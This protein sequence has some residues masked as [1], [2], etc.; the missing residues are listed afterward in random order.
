MSNSDAWL[1][2]RIGPGSSAETLPHARAL[3]YRRY[4]T[5]IRAKAESVNDPV[6]WNRLWDVAYEFELL[7]DSIERRGR[8]R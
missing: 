3:R 6:V 8:G 5:D 7:A 2:E 4:A 1:V